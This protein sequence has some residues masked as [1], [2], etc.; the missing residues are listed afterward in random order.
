[1]P[2]LFEGSVIPVCLP[3]CLGTQALWEFEE[4]MP[5]YPQVI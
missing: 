3:V 5:K 1:M 2:R 4:T